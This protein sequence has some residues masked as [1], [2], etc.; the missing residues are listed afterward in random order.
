MHDVYLAIKKLESWDASRRAEGRRRRPL[1]EQ[2]QKA[3]RDL[4]ARAL[5]IAEAK[6]RP[7]YFSDLRAAMAMK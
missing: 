3:K 1:S 7:M 2:E 5:A 4:Y 6:G